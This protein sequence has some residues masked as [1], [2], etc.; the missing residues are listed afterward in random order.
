[1]A[2][3]NINEIVMGM[4]PQEKERYFAQLEKNT[5]Y[6]LDKV[7]IEK[8]QR[9]LYKASLIEDIIKWTRGKWTEAEL[10]AKS[11]KALERIYDY[12]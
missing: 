6:E 5:K 8:E 1:M 3:Q 7:E 11:I 4:T 2:S 12:C 9:K 10:Q